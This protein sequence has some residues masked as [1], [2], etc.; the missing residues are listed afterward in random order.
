MKRA[1]IVAG[2]VASLGAGI[3]LAAALVES[4]EY[5]FDTK[6]GIEGWEA[7]GESK[8]E[9]QEGGADKSAGCM[10]ISGDHASADAPRV[11]FKC[12]D[13]VVSFDYFAHGTSAVRMR[14]SV[15][16]AEARTAYG[17]Y[18]NVFLRK[19]E[20]DKWQHV[21]VKLIDV[22]G[23]ADSNKGKAAADLQYDRFGFSSVEKVEDGAYILIDN[24]KMGP[25]AGAA[26][27]Q[28]AK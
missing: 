26:A 17:R 12:G 13:N 16:G 6:D 19:V 28:P 1:T 18:G 9:W 8:V 23:M 27:P 4:F 5:K 25:P 3:C 2:V 11:G 10:K 21:E 20:Q 22:P 7:N 24:V 14:L 15:A